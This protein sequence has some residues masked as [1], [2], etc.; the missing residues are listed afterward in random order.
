[1][2]THIG[3]KKHAHVPKNVRTNDTK[4][5]RQ[6]TKLLWS[7]PEIFECQNKTENRH[8]QL[9]RTRYLIKKSFTVKYTVNIVKTKKIYIHEYI[10]I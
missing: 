8:N 5:E 3:E 9:D 4:V 1:M 2:N 7:T 10:C 6:I